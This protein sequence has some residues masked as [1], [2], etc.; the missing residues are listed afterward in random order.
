M[1][2]GVWE[3]SRSRRTNNSKNQGNNFFLKLPETNA[4]QQ[5]FG[6]SPVRP[7]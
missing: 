6:V 3:S 5:S 4:S 1:N 7:A 2:L